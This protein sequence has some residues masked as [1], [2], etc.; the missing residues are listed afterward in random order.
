[1]AYYR[2]DKNLPLKISEFD[3]VST[4]TTLLNLFSMEVNQKNIVIHLDIESQFT[5]KENLIKNDLNR[6]SVI[7]ITIFDFMIKNKTKEGCTYIYIQYY[8][9]DS[10]HIVFEDDDFQ[11]GYNT[12]HY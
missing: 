5:D 9:E 7:F 10:I 6:F 4:V 8:D 12:L 11:V 1:M 2:I 3:L